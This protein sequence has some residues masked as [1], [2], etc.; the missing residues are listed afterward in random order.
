MQALIDQWRRARHPSTSELI[1]RVGEK[2]DVALPSLPPKK[3][4]AVRAWLNAVKIEPP[5]HLT[6]RLKQL[7]RF[8][9]GTSASLLWP[10]FEALAKLPAD[11]RIATL[12][13]R[14]LVTDAPLPLT[15]RLIRRLLDCVETHGDDGH[16]RALELGLALTPLSDGLAARAV[17]L[18]QHGLATKPVG[19]E[20][21]RAE[22]ERLLALKWEVEAPTPATTLDP[23][24]AV[25]LAPSDEARRQVLA[26]VLLERGD[27][28]GEFISLQLAHASPK[29]QATLL[30]QHR[31]AWLGELARLV[32]FKAPLKFEQGFVSALTLKDLKASQFMLLADAREWATV[33]RVYAG[34]QRFSRAMVS[35]ENSGP[36]S[37]DALKAWSREGFELPLQAVRT[38][39]MPGPVASVLEEVPRLPKWLSL[40]FPELEPTRP[41]RDGL[42]ALLALPGVERLR[43]GA[44]DAEVV[45]SL[46]RQLGG[47]DWLPPRITRF[48]INDDGERL[49]VLERD[50]AKWA[51]T[52]L[53]LDGRG[54]PAHATSDLI[55][56]LRFLEFSRVDV[57]VTAQAPDV[58]EAL[59]RIS[60]WVGAPASL[61]GGDLEPDL[62]P[63]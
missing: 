52:L 61:R 14:Y 4:D 24:E 42:P 46:L 26:D 28:R 5:S 35:L 51:M 22:R 30:K 9:R 37:L 33:K 17:R 45:P 48:E 12:A 27:P 6:A 29:R 38:V 11:P 62:L 44:M 10:L 56:P 25:F 57:R 31:E 2:F 16:Y 63:W 18:M 20:L 49:V 19:P 3:G 40:Y 55:R 15:E 47:L 36:V 53:E 39:G 54:L 59:E 41:M 32:D 8:A 7:E 58:T 34:L 1:E 60:K 50:G 21:P 23:L 13:V 43:L